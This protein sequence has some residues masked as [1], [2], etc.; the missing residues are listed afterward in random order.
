MIGRGI[1][2]FGLLLRGPGKY[3]HRHTKQGDSGSSP[4]ED[5]EILAIHDLQPD[6]GRGYIDTA[7]GRVYVGNPN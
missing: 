6:E 3:D 1:E 4:V 2:S 7:I 5:G